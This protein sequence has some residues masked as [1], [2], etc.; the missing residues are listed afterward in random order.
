MVEISSKQ[1]RN[2]EAA[3]SLDEREIWELAS[4]V[5][6][7]LRSS[8]E[9]QEQHL[10]R[11]R[12]QNAHPLDCGGAPSRQL[13]SDDAALEL[14]RGS[15]EA[16]LRHLGRREFWEVHSRLWRSSSEAAE[17]QGSSTSGE[18][19]FW[20]SPLRVWSRASSGNTLPSTVVELSRSS[21]EGEK[22]HLSRLGVLGNSP[23]ERGGSPSRQPKSSRTPP[24]PMVGFWE[25]PPVDRGEAL[26]RQP[27]SEGAAF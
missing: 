23:F 2:A 16:E 17:K 20:A 24:W 14:L 12:A 1:P 8:C 4:I 7:L 10:S 13:R 22:Q 6:E 27:R 19:G 26:S 3:P 11:V 18:G 15:R 9:A 25:F 21:C 5:V